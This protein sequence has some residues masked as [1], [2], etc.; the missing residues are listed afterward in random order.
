MRSTPTSNM[1]WKT[2]KSHYKFNKSNKANAGT[3]KNQSLHSRRAIDSDGLSPR[4]KCISK[5]CTDS[6]S[7]DYS[8]SPPEIVSRGG[9][10]DEASGCLIIGQMSHNSSENQSQWT[11][12]GRPDSCDKSGR[13]ARSNR[14]RRCVIELVHASSGPHTTHTVLVFNY[15]ML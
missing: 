5:E 9:D 3:L 8:D 11:Q 4:S 10:N 1:P 13:A 14:Q 7:D 2:I 15:F 6:D 12:S